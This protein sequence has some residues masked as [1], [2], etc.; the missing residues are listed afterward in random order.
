MSSTPVADDGSFIRPYLDRRTDA[1]ATT[2]PT[3]VS[4][5]RSYTL[6]GGR[7]KAVME[8]PFEAQLTAST[9]GHQALPHMTFERQEILALCVAGTQSVAEV[10]AK[11]RLAIGVVRVLAAD[12]VN[13]GCL[14][15]QLA[16]E[17]IADDVSLIMKLIEGVRAL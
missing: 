1:W 12:L 3:E 17:D 16:S 11:T 8:L 10:S 5:V 2:D 4:M 13:E 7:T 15:V 9:L 6:T 14:E